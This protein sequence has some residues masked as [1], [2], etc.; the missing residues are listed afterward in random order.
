[1]T[2]VVLNVIN[3]IIGKAA[4]VGIALVAAHY[5]WSAWLYWRHVRG[6]R[7]PCAAI[8]RRRIAED[9]CPRVLLQIPVYNEQLAVEGALRSAVAI[10]W[11]R[12]RLTIQLLDDSTDATPDMAAAIVAELCAEGHDVVHVRRENRFG[13]KAG[14]LANGLTLDN[15]AFVAVLDVDFRA[16]KRFLHATVG[17][18]LA[19]EQAAFAQCRLDFTAASHTWT[20]RVQ[21]LAM[22]SH[23]VVEQAGRAWAGL[24][25]QF[26]GT[27]AAFRRAAIEAAGGWDAATVTEDLDLVIRLAERGL[28]GI[29]LMYP[30]PAGE[31]P[32]QFSDWRVQQ[33]RWSTGMIQV[34]IGSS[35]RIMAAPVSFR[36]KLALFSMLAPGIAFPCIALAIGALAF[37]TVLHGGDIVRYWIECAVVLGLGLATSVALTLPAFLRLRRGSWGAYVAELVVAPVFYIRL[38]LANGLAVVRSSKHTEFKRTPKSGATD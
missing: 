26:N 16:P 17:A 36:A 23:F 33:E 19:D 22:D 4:M 32:S 35:R 7:G 24:P 15:A 12:D 3:E 21:Q 31:V 11:P 20:A 13:Y 29:F 5:L 38:A 10:D 34:L 9:D 37:G 30:A 27:G 25:F 2:P 28:H 1:M 14:A 18:L 8:A 6:Q